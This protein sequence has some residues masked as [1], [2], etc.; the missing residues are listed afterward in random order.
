MAVGPTGYAVGAHHHGLGPELGGALH[1]LD[2]LVDIGH[3][4]VGHGDE[5]RRGFAAE[6]EHPVVVGP[7]VGGGDFRVVTVVLPDQAEGGIDEGHVDALLVHDLGPLGAYVAAG[8]HG[9]V[10]GDAAGFQVGSHVLADG[11]Q[12]PEGPIPG[13]ERLVAVNVHVL[14]PVFVSG[15]LYGVVPVLGVDIVLP[16]GRGLRDVAVYVDEGGGHLQSP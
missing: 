7:T 10:P 6:V 9:L 1:L 3:G 11:A 4:D 15:D 13:Q 2:G 14:K 16:Q 8:D 12:G 5:A